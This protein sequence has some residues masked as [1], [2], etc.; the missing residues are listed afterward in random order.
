M[1]RNSDVGA[2]PLTMK[3]DV[4]ISRHDELRGADAA[5]DSGRWLATATVMSHPDTSIASTQMVRFTNRAVTRFKR[6]RLKDRTGD[7]Q[8]ASCVA[9]QRPVRGDIDVFD[10]TE[11]CTFRSMRSSIFRF[12]LPHMP[13]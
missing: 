10:G 12:D 2:S 9:R 7:G 4:T 6:R 5:A 11:P 8:E 3:S 1:R 13:I